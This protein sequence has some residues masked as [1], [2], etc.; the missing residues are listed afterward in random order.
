M[1]GMVRVALQ[2]TRN[3]SGFSIMKN[4]ILISALVT[5]IG[6]LSAQDVEL[7][8]GCDCPTVRLDDAY[9]AAS[10]VFEATA[11][12]NDT[13]HATTGIKPVARNVVRSVPTAFLVSKVIK[14]D[15]GQRVIVNSS[16]HLDDCGFNFL[17]GERYLVFAT[18]ENGALQTDRCTATRPLATVD[19][20]FRDS[21]QYVMAGNRWKG[22]NAISV[23][24]PK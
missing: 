16:S 19:K 6:A 5:T 9:C 13:V 22:G 4:L 24:C 1:R 7:H 2:T 12:M 11:V 23:P 15:V 8:R 17:S 10:H 21:L 14:G 20:Q 18:L 3:R